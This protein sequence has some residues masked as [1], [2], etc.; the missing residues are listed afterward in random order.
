VDFVARPGIFH[1]PSVRGIYT[2]RTFV[3]P[4]TVGTA[5]PNA[6]GTYELRSL[7]SLPTRI[8]IKGK[9]DRKKKRAV[10]TGTFRPPAELG[11]PASIF[12]EVFR[13]TASTTKHLGRAKTKKGKFTYRTKQTTT[14]AV[15]SVLVAGY[16]GQCTGP[17]SPAPAGCTRET[18]APIF[19]NF[20]RVRRK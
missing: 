8:A 17:A 15:Y 1:N 14:L 13:T 20:V 2:W 4:Y 5:T 6:A 9:W 18:V 16:V 3:T 11:F 19:S 12:I 7:A 10:I